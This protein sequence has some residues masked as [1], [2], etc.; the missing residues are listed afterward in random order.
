[1]VPRVVDDAANVGRR[2]GQRVDHVDRQVQEEDP[3]VPS[4]IARGSRR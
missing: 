1:M 3:P 2:E 4:K